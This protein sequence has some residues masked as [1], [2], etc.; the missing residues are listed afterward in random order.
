MRVGPRCVQ[1]RARPPKECRVW[2][3]VSG[4]DRSTPETKRRPK[5]ALDSNVPWRARV[6]RPR[7]VGGEVFAFEEALLVEEVEDAER[8]EDHDGG[9]DE[10]DQDRDEGR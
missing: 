2:R 7:V 9:G 5:M 1:H 8:G 3:E 6:L 4:A 10:H